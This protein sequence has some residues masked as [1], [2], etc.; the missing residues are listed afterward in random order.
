M[1]C[2]LGNSLRAIALSGLGLIAPCLT[3]YPANATSLLILNFLMDKVMPIALHLNKIVSSFVM[4]SCLVA[5]QQRM[6]STIFLAFSFPSMTKSLF[7]HQSSEVADSPIGPRK[8]C[9][10]PDGSMNVVR[11]LLSSSRA[12]C[13]YPWTQLAVAKYLAVGGIA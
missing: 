10:L 11:S 7:L 5:P 1:F 3:T 4:S 6:S 2:G 9:H 13:K 8:Y 12:S